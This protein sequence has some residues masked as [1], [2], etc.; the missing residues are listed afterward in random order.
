MLCPGCLPE[1]CRRHA[2]GMRLS[3]VARADAVLAAARRV[4]R[5]AYPGPGPRSN[6][7]SR[8]AALIPLPSNRN[9]AI[10][11]HAR[12]QVSGSGRFGLPSDRTCR[13]P[14]PLRAKHRPPCRE[15]RRDCLTV[16]GLRGPPIRTAVP[17]PPK[18]R[19]PVRISLWKHRRVQAATS[20]ASCV[21]A[22]PPCVASSGR[23]RTQPIVM[24]CCCCCCCCVCC[25]ACCCAKA[26]ASCA[27]RCE[28]CS[29]VWLIA[30]CLSAN[31]R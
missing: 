2:C 11:A 18:T 25:S 28:D 29:T 31:T 24:R 6:R 26:G 10:G 17:P 19:S 7:P 8:G 13:A 12:R 4:P 3:R 30:C 14:P 21:A 27:R 9:A 15:P 20:P 23:S 16:P 22:T 5:R 1:R